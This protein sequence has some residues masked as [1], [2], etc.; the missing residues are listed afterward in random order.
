M[1]YRTGH[2]QCGCGV[3]EVVD[4]FEFDIGGVVLAVHVEGGMVVTNRGEGHVGGK[5]MLTTLRR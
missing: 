1:H 4:A 5:V 3:V 2:S